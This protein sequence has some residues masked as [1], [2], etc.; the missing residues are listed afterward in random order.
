MAGFV[1]QPPST[2][3]HGAHQV[4]AGTPAQEVLVLPGSELLYEPHFFSR[5]SI[6][7]PLGWPVAFLT[8]ATLGSAAGLR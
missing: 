5:L 2:D 3:H 6:V 7:G 4:A 8:P 1:T